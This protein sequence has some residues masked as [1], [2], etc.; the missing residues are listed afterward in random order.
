MA[1]PG[2]MAYAREIPLDGTPYRIV[3]ANGYR[4]LMAKDDPLAVHSTM[5]LAAPAVLVSPYK[6]AMLRV[7][8]LAAAVRDILVIGLGGGQQ[9]KFL[10]QRLPR[11]RVVAV[12]VD[13]DVVYIARTF[14]HLPPEDD[15][16]SVVVADGLD[17]VDA[18]PDRFDLILCD[19][20]GPHFELPPSLGATPF[21]QGCL[22]ALRPGGVMALNLDRRAESWRSAHLGEVSRIFRTHV[23]VPVRAYQSVLLLARD[24]LD[25][26]DDTLIRRACTLEDAVELGLPTFIEQFVHARMHPHTHAPFSRRLRTA[27]NL[28]FPT[29]GGPK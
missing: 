5:T 1:S 15:C 24:A 13:P 11:T 25:I 12:E 7:L 22:R 26:P 9:A 4:R 16:F 28:P 29:N 23:E 14:F 10:R 17:Y 21:Y 19:A 8:P 3:D 2:F 27:T 20:Y 6:I 18:H